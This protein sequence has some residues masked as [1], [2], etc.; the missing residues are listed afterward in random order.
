MPTSTRARQGGQALVGVLVTMV[1][2]FSLAAALTLI[3]SAVLRQQSLPRSAAVEDLRAQNAITAALAGVAGTSGGATCKAGGTV[4]DAGCIWLDGADSRLPNIVRLDWSQGYCGVAKI[5]LQKRTLIWF[6]ARGPLA[7]SYVDNQ[8][9]GCAGIPLAPS[10]L[11]GS[12]VTTANSLFNRKVTQVGITCAYGNGD[13]GNGNGNGNDNG[14]SGNGNG[15]SGNAN[16]IGN[17]SAYLHVVNPGQSPVVVR[18][19]GSSRISGS[20][21]SLVAP[22]GTPPGASFEEGDL[23]VSASGSS[24]HLLYEAD[25]R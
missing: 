4:G 5:N 16:G 21:Y 15:N 17:R 6:N 8:S 18:V 3:V 20:I 9:M 2:V 22:T 13:N 14:N 12:C 10:P 7:L 1:V 19:L 23:F 25:I 24:S 11:T